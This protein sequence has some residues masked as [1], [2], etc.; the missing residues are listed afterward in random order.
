MGIQFEASLR[1]TVEAY[2]GIRLTDS[3]MKK[4]QVASNV[5]MTTTICNIA[6]R[7]LIFTARFCPCD[8]WVKFS[9]HKE[10]VKDRLTSMY[11]DDEILHVE[12]I[13][14]QY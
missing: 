8:N 1:C 5:A 13:K 14:G 12:D 7:G 4:L 10:G 11:I 2:T 3:D 6:V 9:F